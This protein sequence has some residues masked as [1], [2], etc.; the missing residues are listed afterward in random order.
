M[1]SPLEGSPIDY[2]TSPVYHV[3]QVYHSGLPPPHP[4]TLGYLGAG[5]SNPSLGQL[6]PFSQ[7]TPAGQFPGP[8]HTHLYHSVES[9]AGRAS[10]SAPALSTTSRADAN[11]S[12][13]RQTER[14]KRTKQTPFAMWVGNIDSTVTVQELYEFF[15]QIDLT[16]LQSPEESAVVSVFLIPKSNCAFVNFR[17]EAAVTESVTRF[18]GAHLR[19]YPGAPR[20]ACRKRTVDYCDLDS[21]WNEGDEKGVQE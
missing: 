14:P 13:G 2:A 3:P 10:R 15:R 20:L 5:F 7:P 18:H 12:I 19:V 6:T 11:V 16:D 8:T 21:E 1:V 17:T 4:F 9:G